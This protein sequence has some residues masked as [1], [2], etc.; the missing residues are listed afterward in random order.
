MI[1][2]RHSHTL[3]V[4]KAANSVL[5]PHIQ[6]KSNHQQPKITKHI[7]TKSGKLFAIN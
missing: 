5:L 4:L 6:P 2:I 1:L 3:Y 7:M